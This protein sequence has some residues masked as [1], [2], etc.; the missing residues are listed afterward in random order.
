MCNPSGLSQRASRKLVFDAVEHRLSASAPSG[1]SVRCP[2]FRDVLLLPR[3][4]EWNSLGAQARR[5]VFPV[6]IKC[7][8]WVSGIAPSICATLGQ[9]LRA[10]HP[11]R[12]RD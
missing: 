1:H 11:G 12:L 10:M 2:N 5:P 9:L 3:S 4:A 7:E 8:L 6:S